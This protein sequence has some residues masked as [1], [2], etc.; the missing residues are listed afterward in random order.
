MCGGRYTDDEQILNFEKIAHA[1][2]LGF[3]I[4]E[5]VNSLEEKLIKALSNDKPTIIE[6]VCDDSQ[7]MIQPTKEQLNDRF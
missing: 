5:D 7:Y 2:N 4:I 1:F 6:I 3:S